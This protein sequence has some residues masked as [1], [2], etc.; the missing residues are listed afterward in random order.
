MVSEMTKIYYTCIKLSK[1]KE[2]EEK[3]EEKIYKLN[4]KTKWN[5]F[6]VSLTINNFLQQRNICIRNL[7]S[8]SNQI[9]K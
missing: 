4:K 9:F 1:K 2:E 6:S 8:Q 7:A 5:A 3:K